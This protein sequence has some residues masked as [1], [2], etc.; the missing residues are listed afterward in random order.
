MF[1]HIRVCLKKYENILLTPKQDECIRDEK[2]YLT[3]QI[4]DKTLKPN[5]NGICSDEEKVSMV[6]STS[7]QM[8]KQNECDLPALNQKEYPRDEKEVSDS[9]R[10]LRNVSKLI[11]DE[12]CNDDEESLA[13][14]TWKI[15]KKVSTASPRWI[16]QW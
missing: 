13:R 15:D 3:R 1:R 12:F 14:Q 5:Q 16:F 11:E 2:E 4:T 7:L 8:P 10:Q 9:L 6:F